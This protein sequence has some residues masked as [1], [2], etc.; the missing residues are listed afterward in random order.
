MFKPIPLLRYRGRVVIGYKKVYVYN[1]EGYYTEGAIVT[2][3]IGA[4]TEAQSYLGKKCR[5]ASAKVIDIRLLNDEPLP[6]G[7]RVFSSWGRARHRFKFEY[8]IGEIVRPRPHYRR[9]MKECAPGIHFFLTKAEAR[10]Y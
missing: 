7:C 10:A 3:E 9:A 4:Q 8:E 1:A 6:K 2:L 5:A